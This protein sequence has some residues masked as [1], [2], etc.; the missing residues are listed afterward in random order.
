[1]LHPVV[2]QFCANWDGD[3]RRRLPPDFDS[4][5]QV[6]RHDVSMF[7]SETR[8]QLRKLPG[9]YVTAYDRVL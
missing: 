8:E 3:A 2:Y 6:L 4:T 9:D 5:E 1:M 7:Q